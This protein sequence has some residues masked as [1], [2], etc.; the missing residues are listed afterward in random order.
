[1]KWVFRSHMYVQ[2]KLISWFVGDVSTS[3][4]SLKDVECSL[5]LN[6]WLIDSLS[7]VEISLFINSSKH[8]RY[9]KNTLSLKRI[10][11]CMPWTCYVT[12][13]YMDLFPYINLYWESFLSI[14]SRI[15]VVQA[16][17]YTQ[18]NTG[19]SFLTTNQFNSGN[20]RKH[21]DT[22]C[23]VHIKHR[24]VPTSKSSTHR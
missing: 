10:E 22:K 2:F 16:S 20:C 23:K 8:F 11:C 6:E 19:Y 9:S 14:K 1:M 17:I 15:P 13:V 21:L 4:E 5:W 12:W 3:P 18:S 7:Q 24:R